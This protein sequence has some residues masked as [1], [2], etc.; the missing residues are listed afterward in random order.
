MMTRAASQNNL[1]VV[2]VDTTVFG[3]L[4][5]SKTTDK[6]L[7]I[8]IE[9]TKTYSLAISKVTIME[10][11]SKGTKD[12]NKITKLFKAFKTYD[13]SDE[14]LMYAGLLYSSGIKGHIDSI[15][16][17]TAFLN[18]AS[19]L[20]SNQKDFPEPLFTEFAYWHISYKD[21]CN[22]TKTDNLYHLS[23]NLDK[24]GKRLLEIEYIKDFANN[25]PSK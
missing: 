15:I 13:V 1:P 11:L 17:S 6:T 12:I 18:N 19:I 20:T 9:L 3:N 22:R 14:V 16:A 5:I 10:V 24:I 23:A 21:K 2:I 4:L 8:L 25:S 7:N